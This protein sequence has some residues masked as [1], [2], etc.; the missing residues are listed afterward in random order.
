MTVEDIIPQGRLAALLAQGYSLTYAEDTVIG[1]G[2]FADLRDQLGRVAESGGG[3]TQAAARAHLAERIERADCTAE[4]A[5]AARAIPAGAAGELRR[6]LDA[7]HEVTLSGA[8]GQ[9]E[10]FIRKGSGGAGS[11]WLALDET[12]ERAIWAAS[13]LHGDDEPY[14]GGDR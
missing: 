3:R 7:G 9:Y 6:L 12:P 10:C 5:K 4:A 8:D 14:P 1:D 2:W 11:D 13:P